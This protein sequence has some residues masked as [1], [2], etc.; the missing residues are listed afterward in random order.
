[1]FQQRDGG[2]TPEMSIPPRSSS[3]TTDSSTGEGTD[4][5]IAA[6]RILDERDDPKP[7]E[8][9]LEKAMCNVFR[10]V[11]CLAKDNMPDKRGL[12]YLPSKNAV[13]KLTNYLGSEIRR[14][15]CHEI[16]N[17]KAKM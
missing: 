17:T 14:E 13:A 3:T 11:Y 15:V 5:H 8:D 6:Q 10:S 16:Q 9:L 1:M 4:G 12:Q 2:C 7:N